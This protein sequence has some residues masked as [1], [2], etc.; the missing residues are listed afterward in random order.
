MDA[1]VP[2]VLSALAVFGIVAAI[3]GVESRDG[4]DRERFDADASAH[5]FH[6]IDTRTH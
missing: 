6:P 1:L 2:F 4:F 3:A 5:P